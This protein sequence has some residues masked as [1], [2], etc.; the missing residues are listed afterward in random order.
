M[1]TF[2]VLDATGVLKYVYGLG[3]GASSDPIRQ[4]TKRYSNALCEDGKVFTFSPRISLA[5]NAVYYYLIKTPATPKVTLYE[6]SVATD[7]SPILHDLYEGAIVSANGAAITPFNNNRQS[8][9]AA[10]T[11]IYSAPTVTS[12]GTL[13]MADLTT[14]GKAGGGQDVG[15]F[16]IILQASTNYLLMLT[17]SSGNPT[18]NISIFIKF[19]E[20]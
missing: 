8:A 3:T 4:V 18:A 12:A 17:Q 13:L 1:S 5:N 9:A 19:A 6:L 2:Q 7:N 16:S 14:G 10:S 11:L 15:E 20:T